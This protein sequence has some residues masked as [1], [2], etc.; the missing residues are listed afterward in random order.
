MIK[1]ILMRGV[2]LRKTDK[3]VFGLFAVVSLYFLFGVL[4][5]Y[6]TIYS[7]VLSFHKYSLIGGDSGF[8]GFSNYRKLF[9]DPS[10]VISVKNTFLIAGITVPVILVLA[11]ALALFYN[12]KLRFHSV[13]E[14]IYFAPVILPT[15]AV[16]L[17]WKW[18]YETQG[19]LLNYLLSFLGIGPIPWISNPHIAIWSIMLLWIWKWVGYYAILFSVGL[20]NIPK[21]YIDAAEVDG[22]SVSQTFFHVTLPLLKP[23]ILFVLIICTSWAFQMFVPVYVLT[24]GS[25]GAFTEA[26]RV[27]VYD[28]YNNYFTYWNVGYASAEGTMLF[29]I[30]LLL[31]AI[32][33]KSLHA[34]E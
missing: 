12:K 2:D 22:A 31:T 15:A 20:Q 17:I 19:G 4:R 13:F 1:S 8:I 11:L 5:L 29:L 9:N 32:Q 27:I 6:P 10:F 24:V 14:L 23:I 21:M 25:Q 3:L 34:S 16:A 33:V 18:M 26:V 7:L 30:L 28:M